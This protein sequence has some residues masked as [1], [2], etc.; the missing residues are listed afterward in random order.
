MELDYSDY[1]KEMHSLSH[2]RLETFMR[3]KELK[4]PGGFTMRQCIW[5]IEENSV[6]Y[7]KWFESEVKPFV[8]KELGYKGRS[9]V[10]F[11]SLEEITTKANSGDTSACNILGDCYRVGRCG[12][13]K[14]MED[15]IN[16]YQV[17]AAA[18]DI[19]GIYNL[20]LALD[21]Y[22]VDHQKPAILS[23]DPWLERSAKAGI[24][25]A[26]YKLGWTFKNRYVYEE[27]TQG[28]IY[29]YTQ[30]ANAGHPYAQYNLG[31]CYKNGTGVKQNFA[32]AV[33]WIRKAA[34]QNDP[35]AQHSL[36]LRYK[37]GEGVIQNNSEAVKWFKKAADQGY[38]F[39]Q[40][41]LAKMYKKGLGT[42]T[43]YF[44]S[45]YY[46]R[47]AADQGDTDSQK[48]LR[49]YNEEPLLTAVLTAEW[50]KTQNNLHPNCQIAIFQLFL[51]FYKNKSFHL[52][53]ELIMAISTMVIHLW[54]KTDP[55]LPLYIETKPNNS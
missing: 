45:M 19:D 15:A 27:E 44:K 42:V 1:F 39:S 26:A 20:A 23:A 11:I 8:Q 2:I 17:A 54:P 40:S 37:T 22:S 25:D 28:A 5:S 18:D 7:P 31:L 41:H 10:P 30:A 13:S 35:D 21:I 55:H 29:W 12:L 32:T 34:E 48:Q 49:K 52:P 46:Y 24:T 6:R 47:L 38:C 4:R 33:T 51:S 43:D 14:S 53:K 3:D 50:P 9:P 36:G 16:W